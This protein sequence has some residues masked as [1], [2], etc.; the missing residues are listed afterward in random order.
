[1]K[2][3]VVAAIF[4]LGVAVASPVIAA[5]AQP[6]PVAAV[7]AP[8]PSAKALALT[9]RYVAALHM[10][11]SFKPMMN[12]LMTSMLQQQAASHPDL[13]EQQR[14]LMVGAV[15]EAMSESLDA[16]MLDKVME[17]MVPAFATV[18]TEDELQALVDFYEGPMGQKIVAKMPALGPLAAKATA[19]VMPE[20]QRDL[21][22]R[23]QT[24]IAGLKILDK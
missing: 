14:N 15:T 22:Q 23:V 19:E 13:T 16:G 5:D 20:L 18:F 4:V 17:S 10:N 11:E 9:R 6:A 21:A 12:S 2:P 8:A 7:G 3:F 1:M 24:K